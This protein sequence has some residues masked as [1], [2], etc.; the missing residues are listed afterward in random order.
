[1]AKYTITI[2]EM[3][4]AKYPLFDFSYPIFD[5]AYCDTLESL[6]VN[7]YY[8]RE[9]GLETPDRFKH[10][11]YTR[12]NEIMPYYNEMYKSILMEYNP[13]ITENITDTSTTNKDKHTDYITASLAKRAEQMKDVNSMLT[14][15][16]MNKTKNTIVD[17]RN[18]DSSNQKTIA[19]NQINDITDVVGN[20]NEEMEYYD[21]KTYSENTQTTDTKT[22]DQYVNNYDTPQ[23][24]LNTATP[25][26]RY[27]TLIGVNNT[28]ENE[29]GTKDFSGTGSTDG[30]KGTITDENIDTT[31]NRTQNQEETITGSKNGTINTTTNETDTGGTK[32]NL[33]ANRGTTSETENRSSTNEDET[34]KE[35]T[36]SSNTRK[37]L[38]G[39]SPSTLM[40]EYR[41]SLINVDRMVLAELND[42]FMLV[43]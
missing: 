33:Y 34:T 17:G 22:T 23:S 42:L 1:M 13:L 32:T 38:K 39:F 3:I 31:Y 26:S 16:E 25:D 6:I 4:Q 2:Q 11:L 40:S 19:S 10:F 9:I 43:Y 20:K 15:E 14:N 28:K 37:G 8:Y 12:L 30:S 35:Q 5:N 21:A 7:H 18:N 29:E 41:K 24:P 36:N 27:A